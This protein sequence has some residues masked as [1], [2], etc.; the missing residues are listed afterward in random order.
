MFLPFFELGSYEYNAC[1]L[2]INEL[3]NIIIKNDN[4]VTGFNIG[5][6]D[7]VDAGQTVFHFHIHVIPRRNGDVVNS[8]GGN[9][10]YH[11]I[12]KQVLVIVSVRSSGVGMRIVNNS[13]PE[14]RNMAE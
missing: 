6:N 4:S 1:C 5:I 3:K 11:I 12:K 8:R 7:G 9:K 14:V 2:L 10:K 13:D